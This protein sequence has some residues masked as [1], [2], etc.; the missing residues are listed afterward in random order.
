MWDCYKPFTCMVYNSHGE[1]P[2]KLIERVTELCACQKVDLLIVINTGQLELT[3]GDPWPIL[4]K[5]PFPNFATLAIM[6]TP[7]AFFG[8][9]GSHP[10]FNLNSKSFPHGNYESKLLECVDQKLIKLNRVY[11]NSVAKLT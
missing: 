7:P 9:C 3:E 11:S 5:M 4:D 6:I 10:V 2:T 1:T 8:S